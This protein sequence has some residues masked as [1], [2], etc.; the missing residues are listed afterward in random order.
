MKMS[1]SQRYPYLISILTILL[2][3]IGALLNLV[4]GGTNIAIENVMDAL[5]GGGNR[6]ENIVVW[7]LR[8]PRLCASACAG[9]ALALSGYV[10]QTI[11]RNP[12][13]SPELTGV[14]MGGALSVVIAIV[15]FPYI[16]AIFHPAIAL[17]GG[18][19]AGGL[20]LTLSL[21]R[22]AGKLGLIL[23][24]VAVSSLCAACMM[25]ILTGYSPMSQPAYQ[26]LI[27][28]MAGR[29]SFHL[30]AMIPWGIL[31]IILTI[32]A[33]QPLRLLGL[34]EEAAQMA[35][36]NVR[37][38]RSILLFAALSMT[39]GVVAIAGPIAFVGLTAPHI[40]R[41][42]LQSQKHIFLMTPFL[43]ALLM[44]WADL[45]AKTLAAPREVPLG[46]FLSLIGAPIL[47]YLLRQSDKPNHPLTGGIE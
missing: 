4:F 3:M 12:L 6:F 24:G 13:A 34:G 46:L 45:F 44:L 42:C 28:S 31:G 23:A 41:L 43:G 2:L 15:F 21:S 9:V 36:V 47:I 27:G 17:M 8:I 5:W 29:G 20:V 40:A 35:G 37:L 14:T 22:H 10:M 11:L 7:K 38:W 16:G 32:I 19:I 26:W 39:A 30:I 25:L 18:F 33:R 1:Q